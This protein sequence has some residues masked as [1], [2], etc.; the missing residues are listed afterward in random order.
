[1]FQK[2]VF[3]DQTLFTSD[4]PKNDIIV[5]AIFADDTALMIKHKKRVSAT[6]EIQIGLDQ[7]HNW[8]KKWKMTINGANQYT[9]FSQNI[10]EIFCQ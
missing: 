5:I 6:Q 1:M 2:E 10:M 3:W 8:S 4:F 7:V 9:S